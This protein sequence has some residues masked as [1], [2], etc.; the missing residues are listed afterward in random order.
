MHGLFR[1]QYNNIYTYARIYMF[2]IYYRIL[3]LY[4]WKYWHQKNKTKQKQT[5]TRPQPQQKN[6]RAGIIHS[7]QKKHRECLLLR[8]QLENGNIPHNGTLYSR[9]KGWAS[10]AEYVLVGFRAIEVKW[11]KQQ[12]YYASVVHLRRCAE[13]EAPWFAC[14]GVRA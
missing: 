12:D 9:G 8:G 11:W 4:P 2:I 5:N 6:R 14:V 13:T 1:K 3:S 7:V 10:V